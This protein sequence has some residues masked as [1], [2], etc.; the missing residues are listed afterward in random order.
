[1]RVSI[2]IDKIKEHKQFIFYAKLIMGLVLLIGLLLWNN[3]GAKLLSILSSINLRYIIGLLVVGLVLNWISCLK[4]QLFLNEQGYSISIAR[5]LGLYFIGKFFS[6]FIPSMVGG[7]L[8]RSYLLGKQINSQYKSFASIFLERLTGLMALISIA[9]IFSLINT[10]ILS[11]PKIGIA[12]LSISFGAGILLVLLLNRS[13]INTLSTKFKLYPLMMKTLEKVRKVQN[14]ILYFKGKHRLLVCAMILS[15]SFHFITSLN[16]YLC[17]LA[18]NIYPSF[19]DIAVLT[20]IILLL[21]IIPV[22]PNNIGWW[23]WTFS[24]LLTEAGAGSAEGLAVALILRGMTLVF[25]L[26]GG[27]VFLLDKGA[28][29]EKNQDYGH[30]L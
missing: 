22:S 27:L 17:C 3:N 26:I 19:L 10:R 12:I 18:I 15:L 13:I 21:N 4:W 8:T 16:V 20:P 30:I 23:E 14:D 9:I 6:N 29:K 24:Y 25:S 7:D 11:E 28:K 2:Y 5:L 1:M